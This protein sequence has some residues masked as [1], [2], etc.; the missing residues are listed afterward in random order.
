M[1]KRKR[2]K[3]PHA[4]REAQNYTNPIP[5]RECILAI[6][7]EQ[8][9]PQSLEEAA[10]LLQ[11]H[12]DD[13]LEALRRRLQAMCRDGQLLRSRRNRYGLIS[14]M[15]LIAG[16]VLGHKDGYSMVLPDDGGERLILGGHGA[17][18]VFDGDRVLVRTETRRGKQIAKLVE[19]TERKLQ[20]IVGRYFDNGGVAVVEPDNKRINQQ[21]IIAKDSKL[22]VANEQ[23]VIVD[24]IEPPTRSAPAVGKVV[25]VLGDNMAPGM[26]IDV[27]IRAHDIPHQWPKACVQEAAKLP[28]K[29]RKIDIK[30]REDLR[31]LPFVTID[32]EDAK[33]FDDAIYCTPGK[34]GVWHLYVAIADVSHYVKRGSALDEEAL[35]RGNSVYFPNRVIPMLPE[36]LS[37]GLCSL[38]PKCDRLAMVCEMKISAKGEVIDKR[39]YP[40]VIHSHERLTYTD[41]AA[42]VQFQKKSI[43]SKY[44]AVVS[45]LD[46]LYKLYHLLHAYRMQQGSLYFDIPSPHFIFDENLKLS[47]L[48]AA[49]KNHAHGMVEECMLRANVA[50]AEYILEHKKTGI[51]RVHPGPKSD[52]I[53]DLHAFLKSL[54]LKLGGELSPEPKDYAKLVA[55]IEAR[56][57]APII[58]MQLLR[59]LMQAY[60]TTDC[61]L[62]FGLAFEA[63]SHFTSPI[64]RY[65]DLLAHRVIKT[66]IH[67]QRATYSKKAMQEMAESCSLTERRAE[68]ATR[69]VIAWLKCEYMHEKV[70]EEFCAVISSVCS[71]GFFVELNDI[72][73]EGLVHVSSLANDY[74][75]FDEK[76]LCLV[77]DRSKTSYKLGDVVKVRLIRVSLADKQIDFELSDLCQKSNNQKKKR[78]RRKKVKR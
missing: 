8:G 11:L 37:N 15:H 4:A 35:R 54:G 73:V 31:H 16:T 40:A 41:V 22:K 55:K 17:R 36:K 48:V 6:L 5:S 47:A 19:V 13:E 69:D 63:Y 49:E 65:P 18:C 24:I 30:G 67:R 14:S 59:S 68:E 25:E 32:G 76:R 42:M 51:Y 39:F 21:I 52:K 20:Q 50:T 29:V 43:R 60:Y 27:A 38:V 2:I 74:Y 23:V 53:L 70:G 46:D 71:F 34:R 75:T 77:G 3:D 64:R 33:D 62:H 78:T 66:I 45:Y 9:A 28:N 7:K 57:D 56:A 10:D 61:D 1:A 58:E 72:F 26:E 44:K 12:Q